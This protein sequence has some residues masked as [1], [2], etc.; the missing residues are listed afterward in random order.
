MTDDCFN[1][2]ISDTGITHARDSTGQ[3]TRCGIRYLRD[4]QYV[5]GNMSERPMGHRSESDVDCMTCLVKPA[6]L[7]REI[8]ETILVN[9]VKD[10]QEREDA[11]MLD[12]MTRDLL[13]KGSD[14]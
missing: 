12:A 11:S 7:I 14:E 2:R 5:I 13:G 6:W 1:V 9:S 3:V 10:M 8:R 4:G